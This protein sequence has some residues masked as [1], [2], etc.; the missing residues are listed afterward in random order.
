MGETQDYLHRIGTVAEF[1]ERYWGEWYHEPW[2]SRVDEDGDVEY[3]RRIDRD[4]LR[5]EVESA[6]TLYWRVSGNTSLGL[7]RTVSYS[8]NGGPWVDVT[9]SPNPAG[10]P[11]EVGD[12]IVF[13]GDNASYAFSGETSGDRVWNCFSG[14][15]GLKFRAAGNVMSLIDSVN[16]RKLRDFTAD[17]AL[18]GLFRGCPH[19]TDVSGLRLPATG[20]TLGC[21]AYMFCGCGNLTGNTPYLPAVRMARSCYRSMWQ[22]CVNLTS[23][24]IPEMPVGKVLDE[25]CFSNM[26]NGCTRLTDTV[27]LSETSLAPSCYAQMYEGCSSLTGVTA[28]PATRVPVA[29]YYRMFANCVSLPR[30]PELP[31]TSLSNDCY[32]SMFM[33]CSSLLDAPPELPA[34]V[35]PMQCYSHMFDGCVSLTGI[36]SVL[37]IGRT[38]TG[39]APGETDENGHHAHQMFKGCVSLTGTPL[40]LMGEFPMEGASNTFNT[41][42]SGCSSL[43]EVRVNFIPRGNG[44]PSGFTNNWITGAAE[45][46]TLWLPE[47]LRSGWSDT[48]RGHGTIPADKDP[49]TGEYKWNVDFYND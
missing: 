3:N 23:G 36:P 7:A 15:M 2:V 5:L 9:S 35:L 8:L 30:T 45:Y 16:F 4:A 38:L 29:A 25:K 48:N 27:T 19:L 24:D 21:Y 37:R 41:C 12:V 49:D 32:Q 22:G 14:S 40:I 31:A 47:S 6:G 39:V 10:I 13:R 33:S 17:F 42:F 11:L 43:R 44:Q 1:T 28:L 46:G 26:F 20:L 34:T 18:M